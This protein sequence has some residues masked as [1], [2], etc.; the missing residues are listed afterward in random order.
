M[1]EPK[2]RKTT[3]SF[4]AYLKTVKDPVQRAD[5]RTIATMMQK[6]TGKPPVLWG[7]AIVGFGELMITYA[8]GKELDWPVTA[9][10]PRKGSLTLYIMNGF[11]KEAALRSRLGKHTTGKVCLY[12]KK[13][14]DV[15]L[16]VLEEMIE[17]SVAHEEKRAR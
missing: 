1:S 4:S 15:D 10:S 7:P 8:S 9:F 16:E 11:K 17:E 14:A 5:S 2:T 13:L 6:A 3:T 12:I